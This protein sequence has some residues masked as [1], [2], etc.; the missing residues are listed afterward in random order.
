MGKVVSVMLSQTLR[1]FLGPFL[2]ITVLQLNLFYYCASMAKGNSNYSKICINVNVVF[3]QV[4]V[5]KESLTL[6]KHGLKQS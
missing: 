4:L 1:N 2:D 6:T 3:N 5:L